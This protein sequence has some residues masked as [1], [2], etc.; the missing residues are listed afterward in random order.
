MVVVAFC[1]LQKVAQGQGENPISQELNPRFVLF[2]P[3]VFLLLPFLLF[4]CFLSL[5]HLFYRSFQISVLEGAKKVQGLNLMSRFLLENTFYFTVLYLHFKIRC[6][7][8]LR[9]STS[10]SS[11]SLKLTGGSC[12]LKVYDCP[13]SVY[14]YSC[15]LSALAHYLLWFC[16]ICG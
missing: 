15:S 14:S 4:C 16:S 1:T 11:N 2:L 10:G 12:A 3:V 9:I 13:K 7:V 8:A 6:F 5:F